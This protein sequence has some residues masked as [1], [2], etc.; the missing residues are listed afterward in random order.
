MVRAGV[1]DEVLY[2]QQLVRLLERML[3]AEYDLR[4][5]AES[6]EAARSTTR[7]APYWPFTSWCSVRPS[8]SGTRVIARLACSV[9]LRMASGT[10]RALPAPCPAR[11][12]PSPT[13][14]SA[15]KL[16][17]RPPLTT[18]ATRLIVTTR[19]R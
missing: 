5:R 17:L 8:R 3:Q 16:N 12:L 7:P 2:E 6:F 19:S 13:T 18:L 15:V 10:S 1:D 4:R 9:A 11:P 14:T